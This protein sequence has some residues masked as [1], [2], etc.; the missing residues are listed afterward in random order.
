M[1]SRWHGVPLGLLW[2][3]V[4]ARGSQPRAGGVCL[5]PD[6]SRGAPSRPV[7]DYDAARGLG[8]PTD[9]AEY[10]R[11]LTLT[12][13]Q[14]VAELC[15]GTTSSVTYATAL[16]TRAAETECLNLWAA[17]NPSLVLTEAT[18]AD[19]ARAAGQP[20][21]PLCGLPVALKDVLDATGWPT[22]GGTP[23][24]EGHFPPE[25]QQSALVTRLKAAGAIILGKLRMHELGG[26]DTTLSPVYGPTLNPHNVTHIV[27]GSSG[28]NGAALAAH[29]VVIAIC[30]D[31]G[32]SCRS[33]ASLT[34]TVGFRPSTGCYNAMPGVLGM[35]AMRDTTGVSAR[36]VAD[37]QLLDAVLSDCPAPS[38]AAS[39]RGLRIGK[40]STWWTDV[41]TESLGA[42]NGALDAL[43]AAG[44]VVVDVDTA[45]LWEQ[46]HTTLPDPL[47]YAAEMPAALA[48]Y[49]ANHNYSVSL[50]ELVAS[51]GTTSTREWVKSF[52]GS[53]APS[54][55][56]YYEAIQ[57]G[58]PALRDAWQ[59]VF[60]NAR[61]DVLALPTT[62]LPARPISDVEPMLDL[63]GLRRPFYD[64]MGKAFMA[65]CVA[66]IPGISINAGVSTPLGS[67]PGGL[68][69]GLMLQARRK[70]DSQLLAI[71][72]AVEAVLPPPPAAPHEPACA[73]CTAKLGWAAVSY[74]QDI[75]APS[76]GAATGSMAYAPD[77]YA[78]DFVG[79]CAIK[80][81][82]SGL[83]FPMV[84]PFAVKGAP[85]DWASRAGVWAPGA[86]AQCAGG[87]GERA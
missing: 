27:G 49:L 25:S 37:V 43:T 45:P 62:P 20:R 86:A 2:C 12:A 60:D 18:A 61:L 77:G 22:V 83:A 65:D 68:P 73:G 55:E 81:G 28:G 50:Q 58:V 85:L 70:H 41:G 33:P 17:L 71:A 26:G 3:V 32:G 47:F 48:L 7:V 80:G 13:T 52:F 87:G 24:L 59:A 72:A 79:D 76:D 5:N 82:A 8:Q 46:Y 10:R 63:N 66:G 57:V 19:A 51:I 21:L 53:G 11:L 9:E 16:L 14:A 56:Q 64:V 78:L 67:Y 36:T 23:A 69:I 44:A 34:G 75:I 15:A 54:A 29:A 31:S 40:P 74:P 30:A 42:L 4:S 6:G 84:S 38:P 35:G 39:L 1:P